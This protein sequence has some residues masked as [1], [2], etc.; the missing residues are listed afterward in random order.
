MAK[1]VLLKEGLGLSLPAS[2]RQSPSISTLRAAL[3][4]VAGCG[5]REEELP[6]SF[7]SANCPSANGCL[8]SKTFHAVWFYFAALK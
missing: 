1:P 4:L 5:I 3:V 6:R 7:Q 8:V 2:R